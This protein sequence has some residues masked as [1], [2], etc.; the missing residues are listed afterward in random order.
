MGG[1]DQPRWKDPPIPKENPTL[2]P[3]TTRACHIQH[4]DLPPLACPPDRCLLQKVD[5]PDASSLDDPSPRFCPSP[6][7]T[8]THL[9]GEPDLTH[10]GRIPQHQDPAPCKDPAH[11]GPHHHHPMHG[12]NSQQGNRHPQPTHPTYSIL[13]HI[14]PF[15]SH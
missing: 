2:P 3:P 9:R 12:P 4:G 14:T 8:P 6:P 13:G 7:R 15:S 11:E 1:L 5:A 10:T